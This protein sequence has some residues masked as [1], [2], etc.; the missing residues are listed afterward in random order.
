MADFSANAFSR[1]PH[2]DKTVDGIRAVI[3]TGFGKRI[4]SRVRIRVH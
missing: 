1:I 3:E 4:A 2:A